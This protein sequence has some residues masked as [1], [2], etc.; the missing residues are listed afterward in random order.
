MKA[1][2]GTL[3]RKSKG[4]GRHIPS[5][6]NFVNHDTKDYKASDWRAQLLS[7]RHHVSPSISSLIFALHFGEAADV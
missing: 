3:A 4:R 7:L 5:P 1:G 2:A 6:A